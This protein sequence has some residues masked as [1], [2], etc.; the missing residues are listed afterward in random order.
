[1]MYQLKTI[2]Y[3]VRD[4]IVSFTSIHLCSPCDEEAAED[5][6]DGEGPPS[7]RHREDLRR[8]G[9]CC[10]RRFLGRRRRL[11]RNFGN[12]DVRE[13]GHG[14][15]ERRPPL[16]LLRRRT[17]RFGRGARGGGSGPGTE[18]AHLGGEG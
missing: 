17:L 3:T 7:L 5:V 8:R 13:L 15:Q 2:N 1:M 16:R 11:L 9:L 4:D 12:L 14:P 10:R 18:T 6:L